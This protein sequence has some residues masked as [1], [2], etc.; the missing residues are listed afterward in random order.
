MKKVLT[1]YGT[2]PEAIKVAPVI[3]ALEADS[4]FHG[5]V[6][7]TGQHREMLDQVNGVFR[8]VPDYDLDIFS[9]GQTLNAI[10]AKV[11]NRL[12]PILEREQPDAVIVQGD[13]ST[14]AAAS[15]AAFYRHIPVVHLEAGLRSGDIHSPF[16][17]EANRRITTQIASLH[18]TPTQTNRTNLIR[19]HVDPKQITV[20]GN[21]VIDA[22]L[23]TVGI[24]VPVRQKA[25]SRLL[26]SEGPILLV[27]SHRREN[28]GDPMSRVGRAVAALARR[29]RDLKV[30][31]PAHLN[32]SVRQHLL[33]PLL[34]I[35]NVT[36]CEPLPYGE[37]TRVLQAATIVLTDS[38]GLQEEA[39][40]LGKPVLVL[41]DNTE[42]PEAITAGTARLV[43][44]DPE[45]IIDQVSGLLEDPAQYAAMAKATNPYGDGTAAIRCV[46]AIAHMLGV[47]IRQPDFIWT[48][49]SQQQRQ[50][51]LV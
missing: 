7:A 16:P 45:T 6:A 38:G 20:T 28:L 30:L 11:V 36:V 42:R 14:V 10:V 51:V 15:L 4:R 2:R 23:Y 48:S 12:D 32:P 29:Y 21:T 26:N 27:T 19:E 25:V 35:P 1:I 46:A 33:P 13:T 24:H 34:G 17:E 18:L 3:R 31:L 8:I 43:G 47:G 9:P 50:P 44:T 5:V 41:R 39:P 40:A 49:D 37:F 22:L